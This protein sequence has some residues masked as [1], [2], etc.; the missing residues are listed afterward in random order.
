MAVLYRV[1]LNHGEPIQ[2]GGKAPPVMD[3]LSLEESPMINWLRGKGQKQ[4]RLRRPRMMKKTKDQRTLSSQ[5][6]TL[7]PSQLASTY[8]TGSV[9]IMSHQGPPKTDM[10][11]YSKGLITHKKTSRGWGF[12]ALTSQKGE[13]FSW[14]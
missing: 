11:L 10:G 4:S 9:P 14:F 2:C 5:D 3:S 12:C 8:I 1:A 7:E 13:R 6:P